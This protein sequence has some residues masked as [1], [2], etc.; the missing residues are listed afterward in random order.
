MKEA[1]VTPWKRV[2]VDL[3]GPYEVK[4][5]NK[6]YSLRAMTM[7]DPVTSWFEIVRIKTKSS[8]EIQQVLILHG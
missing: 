7:V 1:E 6:T 3:I 2:N 5:P 4:T 8:A